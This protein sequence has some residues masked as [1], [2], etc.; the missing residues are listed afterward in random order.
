MK[1]FYRWLQNKLNN[2]DQ[3]EP[4][5]ILTTEQ[6]LTSHGMNFTVYKANGGFVVEH[7]VYDRK[8][9]CNNNS[10]HIITPNQ[11]LG[12]ELGKIITYESILN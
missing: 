10:L 1:F 6:S 2:Y 4:V 5:K 9:D 11:D 3:D 12:E 7:R 8:N